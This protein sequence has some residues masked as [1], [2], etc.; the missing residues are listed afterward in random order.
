MK[1]SKIAVAIVDDSLLMRQILRAIVEDSDDMTVVGE[2]ADPLQAREMIRAVNPDVITLDIEMPRMDGLEFLRRL[3]QLRPTP[4]VMISTLTTQGSEASLRAFELGAIDV[5]AKP[6]LH[7]ATLMQAYAEDLRQILR[8]AA[9]AR[10]RSPRVPPPSVHQAITGLRH[11]QGVDRVIAIG[12]STG[13]T[14]ALKDVLLKLPVETPPILIA[15]HMPREFTA[16]F[17]RRLDGLCAMTVSE[18][19]DGEKLENGHAYIAPGGRHLLLQKQMS[20]YVCRLSDGEPVNRHRPSVDVLMHSVATVA[21]RHAYGIILT[22]MGNDG[23]DGLLA[24][25]R[26]GSWTCAEDESSCVVFGMPKVAIQRG[27]VVETLPLERIATA[28]LS[29]ISG[30]VGGHHE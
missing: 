10:L 7:Q 26:A 28:L 29:Q 15:Q 24:M 6:V 5:V 4:V 18:A 27:A 13:G 12:A 11:L 17:A 9:V 30:T 20:S 8:T 3:M 25:R 14:E 2:A 1:T 19:Q 22:G 23:A 21:G 16:S